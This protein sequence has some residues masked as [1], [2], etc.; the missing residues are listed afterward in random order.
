MLFDSQNSMKNKPNMI[1]IGQANVKVVARL[2]PLNK[3]E[4]VFSI[5]I[6]K[7]IDTYGLWGRKCV[8]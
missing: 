2:R 4:L 6:R 5:N 8:L 3:I 1:N 7:N